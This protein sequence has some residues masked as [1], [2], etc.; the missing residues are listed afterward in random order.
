MFKSLR[1]GH[2][3]NPDR[4]RQPRRPW[5]VSGSHEIVTP[6]G[7]HA[8][9]DVVEP[10]NSRRA[11]HEGSS[12]S[13]AGRTLRPLSI[14]ADCPSCLA[15][16]RLAQTRKRPSHLCRNRAFFHRFCPQVSKRRR[17]WRLS[18]SSGI[19]CPLQTLRNYK[20]LPLYL[21]PV[22]SW[23]IPMACLLGCCDSSGP[24]EPPPLAATPWPICKRQEQV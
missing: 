3:L 9:A 23:T 1:G 19:V 20:L 5:S 14:R 8:P 2:A 15:L 12:E 24:V 11:S 7:Q 10:W 17:E 22:R 13:S 4:H 6:D 18:D 21:R 16:R